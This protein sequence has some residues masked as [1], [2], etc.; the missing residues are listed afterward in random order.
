MIIKLD[1]ENLDYAKSKK[2]IYY[3][4]LKPTINLHRRLQSYEQYPIMV[5]LPGCSWT[6]LRYVL[7]NIVPSEIVL[8]LKYGS[9][10]VPVIVLVFTGFDSLLAR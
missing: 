8:T 3:R 2:L 5:H 1:F 9:T 7:P 4:Y 10:V 6:S